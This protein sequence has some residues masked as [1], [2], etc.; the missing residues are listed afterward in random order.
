MR[1][2]ETNNVWGL[3]P[4]V[5]SI[6]YAVFCV[7]CYEI[8]VAKHLEGGYGC[9]EAL[10]SICILHLFTV[11]VIA[12]IPDYHGPL[13]GSINVC[14][15]VVFCPMIGIVY[16]VFYQFC[17]YPFRSY[18]RENSPYRHSQRSRENLRVTHTLARRLIMIR[19]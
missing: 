9:I 3:N 18:F 17:T 2:S 6:N 10:Y 8:L 12:P 4:Y 14:L 11:R 13:I 19:Y 15:F 5:K 16:S 1:V 7:F